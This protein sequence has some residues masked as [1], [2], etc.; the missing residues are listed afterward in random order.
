MKKTTLV[1]GAFLTLFFVA[2][3]GPAGP[4]GL[5]GFDGQDGQPGLDGEPGIEA[6]VFEVEGV[7]F[8][9]SAADNL[10]ETILVFE[11]F[12]SFEVLKEDAILVY[13]FDGLVDFQDGSSEDS[14]GL[15]PQNF[16]LAEGTMQYVPSHTL[17]DVSILIDGN[18]DLSTLSTD[19]TDDQIFRV[20]IIPGVVAESAKVDQSN[21][22][23]VMSSLGLEE[24]DVKKIKLN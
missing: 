6:Q 3:E 10:F 7:N 1:L 5:D 24:K 19:F 8:D 11:D 20:V 4:P 14:W 16:F 17:L 22:S 2:C 21:I 12:T 9:Y 15:I 18:F 13:R 23:A